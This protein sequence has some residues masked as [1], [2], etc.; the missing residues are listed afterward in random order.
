VFR[1]GWSHGGRL[2]GSRAGA[3]A[4]QEDGRG[5]VEHEGAEHAEFKEMVQLGIRLGCLNSAVMMR[6]RRT[7]AINPMNRKGS[8]ETSCFSNTTRRV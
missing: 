1:G 3:A 5:E 4:N 7:T 8:A 6:T 2:R